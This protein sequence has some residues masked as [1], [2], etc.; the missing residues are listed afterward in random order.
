MNDSLT[1]LFDVSDCPFA[2]KGRHAIDG[3]FMEGKAETPE[4]RRRQKTVAITN[5]LKKIG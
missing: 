3:I 2:K 4:V 5:L 1:V